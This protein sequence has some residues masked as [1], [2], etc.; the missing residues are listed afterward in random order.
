MGGVKTNA[1]KLEI[2]LLMKAEWRTSCDLKSENCWEKSLSNGI[3]KTNLEN[4]SLLMIISTLE[5]LLKLIYKQK[6]FLVK[7]Y[8]LKYYIFRI[9]FFGILSFKTCMY[10][11]SLNKSLVYI[12]YT[13]SLLEY[14]Y[15]HL[16]FVFLFW[17]DES[18]KQIATVFKS[19]EVSY[20]HWR[21]PWFCIFWKK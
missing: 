21:V 20:L 10:K 1:E 19:V 2:M 3:Y 17:V 11:S 12:Q 13:R 16:L 9:I 5:I 4:P 14:G 15:G 6:G 7:E 18:I 8:M